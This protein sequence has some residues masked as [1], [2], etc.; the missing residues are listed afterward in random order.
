MPSRNYEL[1]LADEIR[2]TEE[3]LHIYDGVAR[4]VG[5]PNEILDII[6]QAEDPDAASAALQNRF[7]LDPIQATAVMDLQFRRAT[8]RD[9]RRIDDRRRELRD[10]A[11]FLK[12]LAEG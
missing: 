1:P 8:R 11:A 6:L 7:G 10:H 4:A 12:S 5:E 2:Q 9:R 3:Q